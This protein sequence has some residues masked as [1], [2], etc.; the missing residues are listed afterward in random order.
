MASF[1]QLP[2]TVDLLVQKVDRLTS[3]IETLVKAEPAPEP[4]E[5]RYYGDRELAKYLNCNIQTIY[6]L[7]KARK[8]PFR[9]Y[10]RKYYYLRSEIDKAFTGNG[11]RKQWN[12]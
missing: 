11:N 3:L 2:T 6:R 7:K 10:G 5:T 12:Q 8:L 9:K 4:D 1:D